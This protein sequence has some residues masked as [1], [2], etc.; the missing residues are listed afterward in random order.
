MGNEVFNYLKFKT[1]TTM[2]VSNSK[3]DGRYAKVSAIFVSRN[4]PDGSFSAVK[5][6]YN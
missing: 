5:V 1:F 4:N 2:S 6:T 3:S